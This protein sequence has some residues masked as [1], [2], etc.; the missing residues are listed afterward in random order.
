[1]EAVLEQARAFPGYEFNPKARDVLEELLKAREGQSGCE[2]NFVLQTTPCAE[3]LRGLS[4]EKAEEALLNI[5][6]NPA[7]PLKNLWQALS[8]LRPAWARAILLGPIRMKMNSRQSPYAPDR[9]F[10]EM[11]LLPYCQSCHAQEGLQICDDCSVAAYCSAV[12]RERDRPRHSRWCSHLLLS[13][14]LWCAIPHEALQL[15]E[16]ARRSPLTAYAPPTA[17]VARC[18]GE[19]GLES[20]ETYFEARWPMTSRV[21]RLLL[22]ESLS[23]CMS[24]LRILDVLGLRGNSART[25][26]VLL[27][28]ADNEA[29]AHWVELL[30]HLSS[31]LELVL[32]GPYLHDAHWSDELLYANR[33]VS[34]TCIAGCLQEIAAPP[35]P[36]DLAVAFN[37]G[38]IF[39]PTWLAALPLI[40]AYGS[41]FAA[42]AWNA[43]EAVQVQQILKDAGFAQA[44]LHANPFASRAPHRVTD[45]HGTAMFGN[46]TLF[47]ARPS[48]ARSWETFLRP[49]SGSPTDEDLCDAI[50]LMQAHLEVLSGK[51]ATLEL[52]L[53]SPE[54][55]RQHL[56]G[57]AVPEDI[58]RDL[59]KAY[60]LLGY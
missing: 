44:E 46:L 42:T 26:R 6:C 9:S 48:S 22:T 47:I 36:F 18:M 5:F 53:E 58:E 23:S 14:L 24:L 56:E 15:Q 30:P 17:A 3:F 54:E 27:V 43:S 35:G 21:E 39:Y 10:E 16:L 12:C 20:W 40:L 4:Y 29:D 33:R 7:A 28:G 25:L 31:G 60:C 51:R 19:L 59:S 8:A 34:V 1:M 11:R 38:M 45:D 2:D 37:S 57:T 55:F 50:R 52:A 13:R 32:V 41:P 49:P